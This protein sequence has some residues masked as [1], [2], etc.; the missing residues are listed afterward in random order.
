MTFDDWL[1]KHEPEPPTGFECV[2]AERMR[3]VWNAAQ[4]DQQQQDALVC[5]EAMMSYRYGCDSQDCDFVEA[6]K[7]NVAENLRDEIL[8]RP[9]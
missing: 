9:N 4:A 3:Q 2:G 1:K 6:E 8:K 7:S 5:H